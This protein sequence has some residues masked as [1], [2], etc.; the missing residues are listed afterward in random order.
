VDYEKRTNQTPNPESR[1]DIMAKK[2]VTTKV[3]QQAPESFM[4]FSQAR[5]KLTELANGRYFT[6]RYSEAK[7]KDNPVDQICELYV[8]GWKA[9]YSGSTWEEAFA[10]MDKVLNPKYAEGIGPDCDE[11]DWL[12]A[13]QVTTVDAD[14]TPL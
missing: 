1:E 12:R 13:E 2:R 9:F 14:D 10:A 7:F 3:V 11:G 5:A 4:T 6:I 8:D